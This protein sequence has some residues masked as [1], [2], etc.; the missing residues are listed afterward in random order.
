MTSISFTT[1]I[2]CTPQGML[3]VWDEEL[4]PRWQ[5]LTVL[6]LSSCALTAL[7]PTIG[8]LTNL[9]ELY[10]DDNLFTALPSQPS[11]TMLYCFAAAHGN[12]GTCH[13]RTI[14]YR[15]VSKHGGVL[16]RLAFIFVIFGRMHVPK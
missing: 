8:R 10:A 9:R 4:F 15:C 13:N 16:H 1:D 2:R 3:P 6:N 12:I 5:S 7:S 11:P 14:C